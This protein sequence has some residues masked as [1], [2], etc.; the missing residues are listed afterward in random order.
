VSVL[1]R[2]PERAAK[3]AESLGVPRIGTLADLADLPC[4]VLVNTTSVGLRSDA[5]PVDARAIPPAAVVLDAVYDPPQ[6]RLLR[7]AAA[8]GAR[9]VGG[10]W[11]LVYQA[12]EQL[13][14]W[15]DCQAPIDVMAE[16]FDQAGL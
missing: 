12:A 8:R 6:T 4:D 14:I 7:D 9:T 5:S 1:N 2:T 13:R 3:L 15:S 16:A 10:K 11:M